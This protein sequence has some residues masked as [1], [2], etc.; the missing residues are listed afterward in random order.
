MTFE[1]HQQ[2]NKT[3]LKKD[4]VV[5][6]E[7]YGDNNASFIKDNHTKILE[8]NI[9]SSDSILIPKDVEDVDVTEL[10][11]FENQSNYFNYIIN[12][13]DTLVELEVHGHDGVDNSNEYTEITTNVNNIELN[14]TTVRNKEYQSFLDRFRRKNFTMGVDEHADVNIMSIGATK[15]TFSN[16]SM[17]KLIDDATRSKILHDYF[18]T[19]RK[20]INEEDI[21]FNETEFP[22][23]RSEMEGDM[24][25]YNGSLAN[26]D[27]PE[28][29]KVASFGKTRTPRPDFVDGK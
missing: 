9:P 4:T 22:D 17:E 23:I 29:S 21:T 18:K 3:T 8:E 1:A 12:I 7:K 2:L 19:V 20:G 14:I 5:N 15:M 6:A 27:R 13:N 16:S 24:G 11:N 10:S 28:A 26:T 25:L